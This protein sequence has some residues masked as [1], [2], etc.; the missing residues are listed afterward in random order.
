MQHGLPAD[1]SVD[2]EDSDGDGMSNFLEW[3]ANTDPTDADSVFKV[4]GITVDE[5]GAH[6]T[7]TSDPSRVYNVERS[8]DLGDT[9]AFLIL[10]PDLGGQEG[11]M[12]YQDDDAGNHEHSYY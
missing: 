3:M 5:S 6:L 10:A 7:W 8:T 2:N 9:P 11:T 12:T 1:G 4:I